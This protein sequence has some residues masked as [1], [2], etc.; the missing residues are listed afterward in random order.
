G[1]TPKVLGVEDPPRIVVDLAGRARTDV[2]AANAEAGGKP[3]DVSGPAALAG[4]AT[5]LKRLDGAGGSG[6]ARISSAVAAARAAAGMSH[7]TTGPAVDLPVTPG[8]G[9]GIAPVGGSPSGAATSPQVV[10]RNPGQGSSP[11]VIAATS[12]VSA[13]SGVSK[14]NS[15]PNPVGPESTN[16]TRGMTTAAA[17]ARA[18]GVPTA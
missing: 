18:P 10:T 11:Q 17:S 5:A 8:R 13:Q 3:T 12:V 16:I 7:T 2:A 15:A 14:K 4:A 9:T 1:L 6:D